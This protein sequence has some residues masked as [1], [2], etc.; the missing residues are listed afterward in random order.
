MPKPGTGGS[1]A[2]RS[3]YQT[4]LL[5]S[6]TVF[7]VLRLLT[8]LPTLWAP[9]ESQRSDQHSLLTW[10]GWMLSNLTMALWLHEKAGRRLDAAAALNFG[11]AALCGATALL[12]ACYR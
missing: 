7:D 11:S 10:L 9:H 4:L 6:F 8:Y 3:V 1:A 2:A 12:I 5:W